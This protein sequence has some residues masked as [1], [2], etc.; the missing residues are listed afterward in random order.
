MIVVLPVCVGS[1]V[2]DGISGFVIVG[3]VVAV[4]Y[5]TYILEARVAAVVVLSILV[6][7]AGEVGVTV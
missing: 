4:E 3:V 7:F 5:G 1:A 2:E 6:L